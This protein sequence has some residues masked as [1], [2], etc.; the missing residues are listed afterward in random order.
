M[1]HAQ[2]TPLSEYANRAFKNIYK[3]LNFNSPSDLMKSN[4]GWMEANLIKTNVLFQGI[5]KLLNDTTE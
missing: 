1:E 4:C 2:R 3:V 5:Y